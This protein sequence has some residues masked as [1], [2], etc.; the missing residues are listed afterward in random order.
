VHVP[1]GRIRLTSLRAGRPLAAWVATSWL[2]ALEPAPDVGFSPFPF[3]RAEE[4]AL[5][6]GTRVEL[7]TAIDSLP[8]P[9]ARATLYREPAVTR[10]YAAG[11]PVLR[12]L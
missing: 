10:L 11:I 5:R 3:D 1:A 4:H 12:I 2:A 9:T 8:D 7:C 6:P